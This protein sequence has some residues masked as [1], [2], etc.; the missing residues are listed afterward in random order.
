MKNIYTL[1]LFALLTIV[2][3]KKT[4]N[5]A[6]DKIKTA[7]W[8]IGNWENELEQGILSESWEKANDSTFNGK[9]FF[10][11]D[12]DTLNNETIVLSQKGDD[13]F[14]IPVVQGQNNNEPVVFKMTKADAKQ[15]VFENPKHDF[16]QKISYTKINN[17]SIVAA[18]SGV[19]NGKAE[20][21]SYPMKRK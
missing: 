10:I 6:K 15:L 9:S 16:P 11:K 7:D 18:I 20:S 19:V 4:E 1:G 8:L 13:L 17:D 21:E 2:A 3:C 12:K 5:S 14:Y